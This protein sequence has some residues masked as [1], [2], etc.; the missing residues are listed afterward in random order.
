MVKAKP[1]VAV[2]IVTYN[3]QR[4]IADCLQ[5]VISQS[6]PYKE[7]WVVDNGS[8]DDTLNIISQYPEIKVITNDKNIGVCAARNQVIKLSNADYFLTLDSDVMLDENYIIRLIEIAENLPLKYGMFW[9]KIL[10]LRNKNRIDTLGIYLSKF[11]RFYDWG[12][13]K[14]SKE[15]N[16]IPEKILAPCACAALYKRE[17]L[18]EISTDGYFFDPK[19]H[20]L[21]EDFD[22]AIRAKQKGWKGKYVENAVAYH[23][24]HGSGFDKKY[25][26]Y[27]SFRNRYY[28]LKKHCKIKDIPFLI[29]SAFFYDLPRFLYLMVSSPQSMMKAIKEI[30]RWINKN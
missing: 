4:F 6:Y 7:I 11:F 15:V 3:S 8:R 25:I 29:L 14:P 17:M 20:Y 19:F 13:C 1:V 22:I 12:Q 21:V 10:S 26:R 24:R 5:S 16:Y 18:E 2:I 23:Y 28:L 30:W 27:L 9:G